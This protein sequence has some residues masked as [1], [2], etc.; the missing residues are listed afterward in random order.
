MVK[1]KRK[2]VKKL[3]FRDSRVPRF[4]WFNSVYMLGKEKKNV[5]EDGEAKEQLVGHDRLP[6]L[7]K[8][9]IYGT[10]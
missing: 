3:I 4:R 1:K 5:T 9:R 6:V 8:E 10:S 2:K 7:E